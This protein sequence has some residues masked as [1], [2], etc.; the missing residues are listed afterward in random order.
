MKWID[1]IEFVESPSVVGRGEGGYDEDHEYF[2]EL[3]KI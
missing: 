1:A 2:G 3:A